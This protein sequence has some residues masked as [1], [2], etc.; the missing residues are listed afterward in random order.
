M[1]ELIAACGFNASANPVGPDSFTRALITELDLLSR[2]P[3]FT[4][5]YLYS[6]ILCL[7]QNWMPAGKEM[8]RPPLHVVL[9]QC[10]RLPRSIQLSQKSLL[11]TSS[12]ASPGQDIS[13]TDG[14]VQESSEPPRKRR[15]TPKTT[16]P[17]AKR[18]RTRSSSPRTSA[19]P[20]E[21]D[22]SDLFE[23]SSQVSSKSSF[24]E[25]Q[26]SHPRI[27]IT[28]RLKETLG[29][30]ELSADLLGKWIKMM[31]LLAEHV[32]IE[33]GF[34]SCSTLL[35]VSLP[36]PLW[37]YLPDHPAISVAGIVKSSIF[38]LGSFVPGPYASYSRLQRDAKFGLVGSAEGSGMAPRNLLT[39][40]RTNSPWTPAEEEALIAMRNAKMN[41][42][43][44]ATVR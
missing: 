24:D 10:K 31:P 39:K 19:S 22:D 25:E 5:G 23:E 26:E 15:R 7:V 29:P 38:V 33:A 8:Q 37:C 11:L 6:K 14:A 1:T 36:I 2:T 43:D 17:T 34:A 21:S 30:Y 42:I 9:T 3:F 40:V 27:A 32:K 18:R 41:W 13:Q 28:I 44:I 16:E 4:V 35:F 20:Q 12:E